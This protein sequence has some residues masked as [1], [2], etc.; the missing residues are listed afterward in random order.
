MVKLF[1]IFLF[2][3]SSIYSQDCN[4][5][6]LKSTVK[7]E[8]KSLPV[9]GAKY[10]SI[11]NC[12]YIIGVGITSSPSKNLSMLNRVASVKARRSVVLLLGN[13]KVTTQSFLKTEQVITDNSSSY[14]ERFVDE[15]KEEASSFVQGMETL[16]AFYSNDGKTYVYVLFKKI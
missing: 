16:D 2:F 12:R 5:G 14:I 10:V 1:L 7:N 11:N 15:I 9:E 8:F 4:S 13:P 6:T 3:T